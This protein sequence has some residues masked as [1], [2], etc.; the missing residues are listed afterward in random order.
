M[1]RLRRFYQDW[2]VYHVIVRCNNKEMLLKN[3]ETKILLLDSIGKYQ[4]RLGFKIYALVI[5]NNHMHMLVQIQGQKNLSVVMQKILLSFGK[6]YRR[7]KE[8]I[9]HFWQ[10]RFKAI[11]VVSDLGMREVLNYIH[12]NPLKAKLVGHSDEYVF[13]SARQYSNLENQ[14]LKKFI[15]LTKYGDTLAGSCELLKV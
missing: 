2:F 9:G 11:H 7:K 8:F 4:E 10:G 15:K 14:T 12:Q 6:R 5:M 1:G 13:S 3:Y